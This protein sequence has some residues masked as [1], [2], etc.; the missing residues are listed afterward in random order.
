MLLYT[1]L[2]LIGAATVYSFKDWRKGI[3]L[4]ILIGIIKDPIRKMIPDAPAYLA[5]ATVP[6]LGSILI[7]ALIENPKVL[8]DFKAKFPRLSLALFIFVISLI[9]AAVKSAT[10]G[11]G[12]W[13]I[14]VL[15]LFSY[16]CVI[17]GIYIG[18]F[19]FQKRKNI[20]NY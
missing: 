19:Y 13:K 7:G 15:G 10:F 11:S 4:M 12:S 2:I 8:N 18:F 20:E 9:P 5:L 16:I 6:I 14:T 3:Y 17:F 1:F